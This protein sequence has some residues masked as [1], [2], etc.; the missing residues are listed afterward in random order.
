MRNHDGRRGDHL[1]LVDTVGATDS[2]AASAAVASDSD[3]DTN[4]DD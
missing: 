2:E 1:N 3:D 4:D